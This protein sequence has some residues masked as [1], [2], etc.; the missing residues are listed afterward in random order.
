[1]FGRDLASAAR[2]PRPLAHMIEVILGYL[3]PTRARR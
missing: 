1:V 3:R 2:T